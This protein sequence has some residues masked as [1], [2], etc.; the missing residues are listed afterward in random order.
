MGTETLKSAPSSGLLYAKAA[1]GMTP[2]TGKRDKD[3]PDRTLQLDG[4]RAEASKLAEYCRV[5]GFSVRDSLPPIYPNTLAFPLH[6]A[7]LTDSKFPFPAIGLVHIENTIRQLRPIRA[8]DAMS[9]RVHAT[10]LQPHAKG[11][12]F[13][14]ITEVYVKDEL[15]STAD[16]KYLRRGKSS[17]D[18]PAAAEDKFDPAELPA[19]AE[20]P[21]AGD[22]GRRYAS[23]SG[24]R[25]PI[26][27]HD[28]TAKAFG[29]PKAIAH[30]MSTKASCLAALDNRLPDAFEVAVRFRK[31][32]L[33]PSTVT[34]A[35]EEDETGI[36]FAVRNSRIGTLHLDGETQAI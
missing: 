23:V 30:G 26:H 12:Q 10:K 1:L 13:S 29:F 32:I 16:S 6:M 35:W 8:A 18:A 28:L 31:P 21:L 20:W 33:L 14:V 5:T 25:N 17:T 3:V 27:M 7:L 11:R 4:V 19:I 24:D 2:L 34:F 36:N 22:L 9:L 15:V